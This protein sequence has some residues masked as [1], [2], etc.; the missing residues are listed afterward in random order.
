MDAGAAVFP[1]NNFG[2]SSPVAD[3][4]ELE[5][6]AAGVVVDPP[7]PIAVGV[8]PYYC[9]YWVSRRRNLNGNFLM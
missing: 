4:V 5:V 7:S 8:E 6:A 3:T 2:Y 1:P 9:Q